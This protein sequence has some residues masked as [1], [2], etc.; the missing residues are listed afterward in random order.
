MSEINDFLQ[1]NKTN[2]YTGHSPY[3]PKKEEILSKSPVSYRSYNRSH[4]LLHDREHLYYTQ[5]NFNIN[6]KVTSK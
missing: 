4:E 6:A 2:S 3:L 1:K 5:V